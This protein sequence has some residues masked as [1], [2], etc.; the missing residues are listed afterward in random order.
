[1]PDGPSMP[2]LDAGLRVSLHT[3]D[4]AMFQTSLSGEYAAL[5]DTFD[6]SWGDV[7]RLAEDAIASA[8]CSPERKARLLAELD[9]TAPGSAAES[10]WAAKRRGEPSDPHGSALAR[11]RVSACMERR[12]ERILSTTTHHGPRCSVFIATSLDGYIAHQDGGL[13]WL[14]MVETEGEDYG[15]REFFDS[16]DVL[17]LGRKSYDVVLGFPEWLYGSKRCIVLTHRPAESRHGEEFYAGS[18]A[19]L[20]ERLGAEGVRRIYVD[21]GNVIRQFLAAGLLDDLTLSLIPVLLGGGIPLFAGGE[22]EVPL[23]LIDSRAWPS[24][25]V[26]LRYE[27]SERSDRKG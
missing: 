11:S 26:Q 15:F 3:D 19:R 27:L 6:L 7:R 24:G 23:R 25:L 13:D 17:V 22:P 10:C 1:M 20:V 4:P 9:R 5:M 21:G 16:V 12:E 14:A 8:W 18:P 2:F